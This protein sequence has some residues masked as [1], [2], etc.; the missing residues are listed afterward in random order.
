MTSEVLRKIL[1]A[2]AA[3]AALSVAACHKNA[4]EAASSEAAAS[5]MGRS[6]TVAALASLFGRAAVD[7]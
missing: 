7:I 6:G 4:E 2:G 3:V 1:V 5:D